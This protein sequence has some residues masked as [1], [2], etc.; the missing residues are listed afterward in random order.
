M[1]LEDMVEADLLDLG[2]VDPTGPAEVDTD[3][4]EA[5]TDQDLVGEEYQWV[6][7]QPEQALA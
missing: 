5:A 6:R 7:W 1:H 4:A 2:E 3:Q